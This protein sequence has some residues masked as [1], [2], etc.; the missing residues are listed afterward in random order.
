MDKK[1]AD[2]VA[3]RIAEGWIEKRVVKERERE[4]GWAVCRVWVRAGRRRMDGRGWIKG[5]L[6]RRCCLSLTERDAG[7]REAHCIG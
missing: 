4:R 7:R 1:R 2:G 3:R 6:W 5:K